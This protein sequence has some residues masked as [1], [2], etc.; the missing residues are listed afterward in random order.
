MKDENQIEGIQ[1]FNNGKFLKAIEHFEKSGSATSCEYLATI[2]FYQ[3]SVP[4][5]YKKSFELLKKSTSM[6]EGVG[7]GL[8]G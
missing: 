3:L 2:Y 1:N 6:E 5:D 4:I 8:L 7:C